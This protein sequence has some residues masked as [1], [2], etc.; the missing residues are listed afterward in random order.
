M[1]VCAV[2]HA[3]ILKRIKIFSPSGSHTVLIFPHQTV[4]QYSYGD[5]PNGDVEFMLRGMKKSRFSTNISL[6]L[7]NDTWKSQRQS[8]RMWSVERRHFQW[9][10]TTPNPDV[11]VTPL[12]D[13][14]CIRNCVR[15]IGTV[16][17]EC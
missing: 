16:A 2:P 8:S 9:P 6:Y 10:W 15:D 12:F 17:I 1:S 14:E 11:K 5:H 3:D 4:G 7:G 13:A